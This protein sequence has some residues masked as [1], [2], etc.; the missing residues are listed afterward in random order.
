MEQTMYDCFVR[1]LKKE[2]VPA[3]GCTEPIALA[4]AAAK[5]KAT[6]AVLDAAQKSLDA[7]VVHPSGILGSYDGGKTTSCLAMV[8][9]HAYAAGLRR[10][11]ASQNGII[12]L[13][14]RGF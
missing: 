7:V 6:L 11:K 9:V 2:L 5:A 14:F 1:I 3:L 4:Y 10:R 13:R 12:S 8:A